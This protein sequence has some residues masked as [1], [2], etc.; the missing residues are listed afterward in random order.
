MI[1]FQAEH[2]TNVV[3]VK[4]GKLLESLEQNKLIKK[5]FKKEVL[6]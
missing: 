1:V 6:L 3:L 4:S 5:H 2:E